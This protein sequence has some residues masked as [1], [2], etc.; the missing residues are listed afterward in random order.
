[1]IVAARVVAVALA[2]L[3]CAADASAAA[4][5]IRRINELAAALPTEVNARADQVRPLLQEFKSGRG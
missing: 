3:T 5:E 2:V 4:G 1:M